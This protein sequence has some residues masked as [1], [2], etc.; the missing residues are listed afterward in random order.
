MGCHFLLQGT[1]LTQGSK[2]G[3]L[4]LLRWQMDSLPLVPFQSNPQGKWAGGQEESRQGAR[5]RTGA[6]PNP[7][8]LARLVLRIWEKQAVIHGQGDKSWPPEPPADRR[9]E[10][11]RMEGG[12]GPWLSCNCFTRKLVN[13]VFSGKVLSPQEEGRQQPH[14]FTPLRPH[15]CI[16]LFPGISQAEVRPQAAGWASLAL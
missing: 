14:H 6:G 9:E 7:E 2:L 12:R 10:E 13:V 8:V 16:S 4:H 3:L 11:G 5:L 15:S 1:L